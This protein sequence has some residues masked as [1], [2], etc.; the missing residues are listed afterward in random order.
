M[1]HLI[2]SE[3][4]ALGWELTLSQTKKSWPSENLKPSRETDNSQS[5]NNVFIQDVVNHLSNKY[6]RRH[7]RWNA[8]GNKSSADPVLKKLGPSSAIAQVY[9]EG[10]II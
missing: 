3:P 2:Y 6:P 5:Q 8:A 1:K 7:P 4:C 9:V 10:W